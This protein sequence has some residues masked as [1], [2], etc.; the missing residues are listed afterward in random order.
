MINNLQRP[1]STGHTTQGGNMN[2]ALNHII[3]NTFDRWLFKSPICSKSIN[4]LRHQLK[5]ELQTHN[6][7]SYALSLR[8]LWH[9]KE[10]VEY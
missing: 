3:D 2:E 9:F 5:T 4:H 8:T 1:A 10:A 7:I 6:Q